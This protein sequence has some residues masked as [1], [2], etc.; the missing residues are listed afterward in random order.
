M[1][2]GRDVAQVERLSRSLADTVK[3]AAEEAA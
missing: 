1:V 2:E 3:R